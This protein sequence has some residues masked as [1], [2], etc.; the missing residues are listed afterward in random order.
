[1]EYLDAAGAKYLKKY[2]SS[3]I[4]SSF[5]SIQAIEVGVKIFYKLFQIIIF[6]SHRF[7]T[8]FFLLF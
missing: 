6:F 2:N 5:L 4:S 1:M 8:E 3:T 7:Y